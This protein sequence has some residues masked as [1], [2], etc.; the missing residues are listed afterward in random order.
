MFELKLHSK[1]KGSSLELAIT[2]TKVV[3]H[4]KPNAI[5]QEDEMSLKERQAGNTKAKHS[6]AWLQPLNLKTGTIPTTSPSQ[7]AFE[8]LTIFIS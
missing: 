3:I 2:W 5:Q 1:G 7:G 4:K 8:I 6:H